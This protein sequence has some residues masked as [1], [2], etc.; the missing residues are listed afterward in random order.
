MFES[1]GITWEFLYKSLR[2]TKEYK[3][4]ADPNDATKVTT[5]QKEILEAGVTKFIALV[6]YL[7][8]PY[9]RF[10]RFRE[11]VES[12]YAISGVDNLP[13]SIDKMRETLMSEAFRK[14][15]KEWLD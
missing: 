7:G 5:L 1:D 4:A 8:V 15:T 10:G 12:E 6:A 2:S 13:D 11:Q 3:A 14:P 9:G